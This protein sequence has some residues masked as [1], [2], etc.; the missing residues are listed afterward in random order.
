MKRVRNFINGC[1]TPDEQKIIFFILLAGTTGMVIHFSGLQGEDEI[2]DSLETVI[3][4]PREIKYDI[5]T[6]TFQELQTISGIGPVRA[7]AIIE[8]RDSN[9][10]I[11]VG[12]LIN[13]RGIGEK[14]LEN[15]RT[16]FREDEEGGAVRDESFALV[17]GERAQ[18]DSRAVERININNTTIE[19]LMQVKGIGQVR[20]ERIIEYLKENGPIKNIDQ[21]QEIRGIGPGTIEN[22]KEL[23]HANY[24]G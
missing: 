11:R 2:I 1:L 12:D 13:V 22:I 6:V 9:K 4:E 20:A 3:R 17:A 7:E 24:D 15:I 19:E 16:Y 14:T 8:Y 18:S 5:N 10:P 21:L 23:F